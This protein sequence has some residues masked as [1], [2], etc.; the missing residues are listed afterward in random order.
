MAKTYFEVYEDKKG[1]FR[2]RLCAANGESVA[3]GGEGYATK[4]GATD[5]T[6]KLKLWAKTDEMRT[7]KE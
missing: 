7:V 5:A 3:V 1:E 2:W 6:K 4:N